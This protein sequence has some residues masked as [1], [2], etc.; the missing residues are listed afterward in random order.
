MAEISVTEDAS[1]RRHERTEAWMKLRHAIVEEYVGKLPELLDID[2]FAR[3]AGMTIRQIRHAASSGALVI[4]IRS[5]RRGI[6]PADNIP[7]LLRTRLLRLHAA[8]PVR[9]HTDPRSLPVSEAAY[10][11]VWDEAVRT[12]LTPAEALEQLILASSG[13]APATSSKRLPSAPSA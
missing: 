4:S 2:E 3:L 6:A 1:A 7:F 11:R 13:S 8:K 5:G 9:E 10:E 12:S